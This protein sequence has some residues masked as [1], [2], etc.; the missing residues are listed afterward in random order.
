VKKYLITCLTLILTFSFDLNAQ[1]PTTLVIDLASLL[2]AS[3]I[4]MMFV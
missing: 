3:I 1:T 2:S 4:G